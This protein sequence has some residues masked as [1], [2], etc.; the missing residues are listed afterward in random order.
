MIGNPDFFRIY[1]NQNI[2][3]MISRTCRAKLGASSFFQFVMDC[4]SELLKN[5]PIIIVKNVMVDLDGI[6]FSESEWNRFLNLIHDGRD[7]VFN[8]AINQIRFCRFISASNIISDSGWRNL[9]IVSD[10]TSDRQR[11]A[12]MA[13][14][15]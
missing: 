15:A 5:V 12:V 11:I 14:S 3:I 6:V 9:A 8:I 7:I 2:Y 4:F 1:I 10:N 13:I